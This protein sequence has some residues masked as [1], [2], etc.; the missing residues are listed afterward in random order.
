MLVALVRVLHDYGGLKSAAEANALLEAGNYRALNQVEQ[1]IIF[2]GLEGGEKEAEPEPLPDTPPSAE[3][4][5]PRWLLDLREKLRRRPEE[6][7]LPQP[8]ALM[9]RGLGWPGGHCSRADVLQAVGW[10]TAWL[11]VWRLTFPFMDWPFADQPTALLAAFSYAGGSL[12]IPLLIGALTQT[13]KHP[14]WQ[15]QDKAPHLMVRLYTYQGAY[16][17]FQIGYLM[18]FFVALVLYYLDV[19][20]V[21]PLVAGV[22]AAWPVVLGYI[23]ARAVPSNLWRASNGLSWSDGGIFFIF[24]PLGPLWAWGFYAYHHQF[25]D[26]TLGPTTIILAIGALAAMMAWQHR[27][28][29]SSLIPPHVWAGIFGGLL[30]LES[31]SSGAGLLETSILIGIVA[32]TVVLMAHKQ[33]HATLAGGIGLLLVLGLLWLILEANLW[34]GRVMVIM[35]VLAWWRWGKQYVWFPLAYWA[36]V[37]AGGASAVLVQRSLLPE[38]AAA[39]L[40]GL[41]TLAILALA[42]RRGGD[43]V[44]EPVAGPGPPVGNREDHAS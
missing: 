26:L 40:F 18:V 21:S 2:P 5:W 10:V 19:R 17:G 38:W 36:V 24:I 3:S 20:N 8:F 22:A 28:T 44:G 35:A 15:A 33:L 9:L 27:R 4:P 42:W 16:I 1:Q 34:A 39:G 32:S 14:Y 7:P 37:L 25:L 31:L 6:G 41:A 12:V 11:L 43:A 30:V 13:S 23:A 29:G